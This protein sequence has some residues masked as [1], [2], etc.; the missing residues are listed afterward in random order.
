MTEQTHSIIESQQGED[1]RALASAAMSLREKA[2]QQAKLAFILAVIIP[3]L[4]VAVKLAWD[5]AT[6]G[7]VLYA[8]VMLLVF[9]L[10]LDR[11]RATVLTAAARALEKYDCEILA[12]GWNG[13][14]A[15]EEPS[16]EALAGLP[17][18]T[19]PSPEDTVDLYPA[20]VDQLPL[21]YA[22]VASQ[23]WLASWNGEAAERYVSRLWMGA[24]GLAV[25]A[26][27][28]GAAIRPNV[29]TALTTAIALTPIVY[30]ILRQQRGYRTAGQLASRIGQRAESA[31]R[32]AMAE[33]IQGPALDSV[34]RGIQDDIFV[35]RAARPVTPS[36]AWR[37]FW[38][39]SP[40]GR[41]N[42]DQF[43]KD[44]V[45]MAGGHR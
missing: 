31:W 3:T 20:E 10:V 36:W 16:L 13:R 29:E 42:F 43:R 28:A 44:Y 8:I 17:A 1:A 25:V 24:A 6:P 30:W 45:R 37:R 23:S 12:L 22:R 7:A 14:V 27:G 34:A 21:P 15:G 41:P 9:T 38:Q 32:N 35:F 11:S 26:L 4:L 5:P 18:P 39:A 40:T 2:R 19:S 33:T